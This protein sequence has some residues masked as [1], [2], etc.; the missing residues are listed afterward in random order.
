[1]LTDEHYAVEMMI[2]QGAPF[3]HI[4]DYINTL[5]LPSEQLSALWLLAWVEA[6]NPATR[7]R[8]RR[9]TDATGER[10][11]D[12]WVKRTSAFCEEGHLTTER[13]ARDLRRGRGW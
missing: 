4:E 10:Q 11:H 7:K 12:D 2:S 3:E 9:P 5:A 1:M 13:F 6:T 8:L